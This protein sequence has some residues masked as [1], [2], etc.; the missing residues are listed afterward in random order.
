MPKLQ[1]GWQVKRCV[2]LPFPSRLGT[3]FSEVYL[4]SPLANRGVHAVSGGHRILF[5]VYMSNSITINLTIYIKW[6][7]CL[8]DTNYQSSFSQEMGSLKALLGENSPG[9]SCVSVC[10]A[11]RGFVLDGLLVTYKRVGLLAAFTKKLK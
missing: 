4:E 5:L 2:R 7:Q 10:L 8:R 6:T 9:L 1:K 3:Q 11:S